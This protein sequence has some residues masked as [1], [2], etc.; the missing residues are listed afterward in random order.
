MG[1]KCNDGLIDKFKK[2]HEGKPSP[3]TYETALKW[4]KSILGVMKGGDRNS[5]IE[6]IYK[7]EKSK[8]SPGPGAH[9]PSSKYTKKRSSLGKINKGEREAFT[10][11]AEFLGSTVPAAHYIDPL[12]KK[13][14]KPF[15]YTLKKKAHLW[16]VDKVD[17]PD[18]Q[19]YPL[20]EKGATL[21]TRAS[22]KWKQSNSKRKFFTDDAEK[23]TRNCPGAGAYNSIDYSKIHRRISTKRH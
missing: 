18:P 5:Y 3:G 22:P 12:K 23:S 15:K 11:D 13:L 7:Q 8:P 14:P 1:P 21:T 10:S 20:K 6:K 19:S 4:N 9:S 16:K 17:G 2:L